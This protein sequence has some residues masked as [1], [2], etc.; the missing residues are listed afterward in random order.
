MAGCSPDG[1]IRGQECGLEIKCPSAAVHV[2]YLLRGTL[3]PEYAPQVHGSI[4]ITGFPRWRFVS[5]RRHFP[6]LVLTVERDEEIMETI[7]SAL[8]LWHQK[9]SDSWEKMRH[10]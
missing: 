4:F 2:K 10:L 7:T 8:D 3:P 1:I 5:Y 6:P 9:F